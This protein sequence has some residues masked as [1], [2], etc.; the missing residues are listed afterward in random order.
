MSL[1]L[2]TLLFNSRSSQ[3]EKTSAPQRLQTAT[4]VSFKGGNLRRIRGSM[5]MR[6][7]ISP[8]GHILL[9][10]FL[11][12]SSQIQCNNGHGVILVLFF[13]LLL[14]QQTY[15]IIMTP[16]PPQKNG[17]WLVNH[18][19]VLS[20]FKETLDLFFPLP[21]NILG[22]SCVCTSLGSNSFSANLRKNSKILCSATSLGQF[23]LS[24]T[25]ALL[26]YVT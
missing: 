19:L 12:M 6:E 24:G 25:E 23:V 26:G 22:F 17:G 21:Y 9:S 7:V 13:K 1:R 10:Q 20:F 2:T 4:F 18:L 11:C 5:R 15:N 8:Y 14:S 16:L 3:L